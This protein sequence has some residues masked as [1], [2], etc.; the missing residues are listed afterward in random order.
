MKNKT[1]KKLNKSARASRA[2]RKTKPLLVLSHR[3]KHLQI[4]NFLG[5]INKCTS[6]P[7]P[8][9]NHSRTQPKFPKSKSAQKER[10]RIG[11]VI[12]E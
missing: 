5:L 4:L 12:S 7:V 8:I 11:T 1:K 10:K 9:E 3:H 2:A 6:C